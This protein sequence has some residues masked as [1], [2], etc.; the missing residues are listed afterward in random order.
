MPDSQTIWRRHPITLSPNRHRMTGVGCY[1]KPAA[2]IRRL[3]SILR[4][5]EHAAT[6]AMADHNGACALACPVRHL[7]ASL[8]ESD[9]A[10]GLSAASHAIRPDQVVGFFIFRNRGQTRLRIVMR[11][12]MRQT[13]HLV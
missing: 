6:D 4:K 5:S 12:G 8:A 2:L 11:N 7:L 13:C 9:D 3:R 10:T 1:G